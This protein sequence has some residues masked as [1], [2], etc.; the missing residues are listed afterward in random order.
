[1][2]GANSGKDGRSSM[3]SSTTANLVFYPR[4]I[5]RYMIISYLM[6]K[7][8]T[9]SDR[10]FM[11]LPLHLQM[12]GDALVFTLKR[13]VLLLPKF[14]LPNFLSVVLGL[15]FLPASICLAGRAAFPLMEMQWRL[16]WLGTLSLKGFL[17]Q[18]R[19]EKG[20]TGRV[21][22]TVLAVLLLEKPF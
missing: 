9:F 15:G 5:N 2:P 16:P 19:R 14:C 4:R 17:F 10:L 11:V 18:E 3:A 6:L 21:W 8:C 12:A 7:S 1:M 22:T 13:M 20:M